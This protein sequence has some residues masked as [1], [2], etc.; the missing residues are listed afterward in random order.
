M[1]TE[2]KSTIEAHVAYSYRVIPYTI[3]NSKQKSNTISPVYT[4]FKTNTKK[5]V[6]DS[7]YVIHLN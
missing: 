5:P 2:N 4:N 6:A 7:N 3:T 1:Y